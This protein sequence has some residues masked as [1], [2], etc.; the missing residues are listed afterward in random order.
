M[1]GTKARWD[2]TYATDDG[3]VAQPCEVLKRY[4]ALLPGSGSVLDVACGR[5]GNA[6][7][8]ASHGLTTTAIDI[9]DNAIAVVAAAASALNRPVQTV[10]AP[11]EQWLANEAHHGFDVIVVSRFL[12]RSLAPALVSALNDNG[13]IYYQT[14]VKDKAD[15]AVG[16]A[17]PDYLLDCNELLALFAGLT[18]RAF[19]DPGAIG[20]RQ[21]GLRN[22]SYL[23]AQKVLR[24]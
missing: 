3:T 21:L 2:K 14:F 10:A 22:E 19:Y 17:N 20:N 12:D 18:V 13:L 8:T 6:L 15:A 23:V 24:R 16:P 4:A 7:F 9:S 11:V 1:S 5:G